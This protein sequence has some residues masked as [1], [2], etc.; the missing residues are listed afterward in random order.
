MDFV[1]TRK[2]HIKWNIQR[3]P[4]DITI[5]RTVKTRVGGGF[6]EVESNPGPFTVRIYQVST[7]E[8]KETNGVIGAKQTNDS[9]SMLADHEADLKS[10]TNVEDRFEVSGYGHFVITAVR[11]QIVMNEIVGYQADLE[12]VG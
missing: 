3:N 10:G 6:D 11:P 12:R 2:D 7:T 1:K 4:T 9:W 5:N 8:T